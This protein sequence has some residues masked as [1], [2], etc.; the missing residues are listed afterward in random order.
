MHHFYTSLKET[1]KSNEK[2]FKNTEHTNSLEILLTEGINIL[3]TNIIENYTSKKQ[4]K[5]AGLSFYFPTKKIHK[6]YYM[7]SFAKNT[8]IDFLDTYIKKTRPSYSW[9]SSLFE[10]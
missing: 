9:F 1:L 4:P 3:E 6:S 7:T 8:W 5:A 2:Q 10:E